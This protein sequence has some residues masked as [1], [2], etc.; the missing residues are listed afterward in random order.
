[1]DPGEFHN[2]ALRE[3]EPVYRWAFHLTRRAEDAEELVQE[4]YLRALKASASVTP[5]GN[6]LRPWLL[7][8]PAMSSTPA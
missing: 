2:L 3:L 5:Q 8:S 7:R 4:T 1:V 6:S